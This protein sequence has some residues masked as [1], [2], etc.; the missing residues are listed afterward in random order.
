MFLL[1]LLFMLVV[2]ILLL[3]YPLS[4]IVL[5]KV[6]IAWQVLKI[7][8]ARSSLF[9][10]ITQRRLVASYRHFRTTYRSILTFKNRASYI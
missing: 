4:G 9:W 6:V 3:I 8:V 10:D 1:S 7:S 2:V 5:E